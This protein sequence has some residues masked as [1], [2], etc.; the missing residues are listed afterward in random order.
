MV[1]FGFTDGLG[2]I[3]DEAVEEKAMEAVDAV[4]GVGAV[5][6]GVTGHGGG[7][8]LIPVVAVGIGD[9]CGGGGIEAAAQRGVEFV[10]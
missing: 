4:L 10:D 8:R 5:E 7:E 9:R 2:L 3:L 1:L 6:T